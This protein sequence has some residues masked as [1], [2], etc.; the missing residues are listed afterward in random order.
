MT[1]PERAT[2]IVSLVRRLGSRRQA[3]VDAARARLSIAG[4]R[5]VEALVQSLEEDDNR[6]RAHAMPLL[7]LIQDARGREPL[8]AM[9]LDREPKMREI[10]AR[11][12]ARFPSVDVVA[13]LERLLAVERRAEVRVAGVQALIEQYAAGRE[14]AIRQPLAVLADPA[15]DPRVRVAALALL[16]ILRPAERKAMLRRLKQDASPE[17][18]RRAVE[19]E[20]SADRS[21]SEQAARMRA[22]VGALASD[23]YALWNAAVHRLASLGAAVIAPLVDEMQRR[24]HDPEYCTRAGMVLKA[25]G[26]RRARALGPLLDRIE[27]P[28]PLQV[29]VD[30]VGALGEKSLVYRLNDLIERVAARPPSRSDA[31]GF[32]PMQRVRAKAHLELARIGS[33]VAIQDLRDSLSDPD[34]RVELEML[35]ALEIVGKRDEVAH[36]LRAF[37]REDR[38]VRDRIASTVRAI[39]KRERIRRNDPIFQTLG[40]RERRA[41]DSILPPSPAPRRPLRPSATVG[42]R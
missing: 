28:L 4:A 19:L 38:F 34:Q 35:A 23:D 29:L 16:P 31:N 41:L 39:M 10:A 26:P 8:T 3:V 20:E 37:E 17:V 9:L 1:A 21:T 12:L 27:E 25:L 22:E 33:R 15:D 40:P 11:C 18:R 36:L 13:A 14:E 6:I 2:E 24:A 42:P 5:A 32:D 7:A 30:V